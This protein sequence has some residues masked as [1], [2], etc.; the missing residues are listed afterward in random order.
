MHGER[1]NGTKPRGAVRNPA[2]VISSSPSP[3]LP[4]PP[5]AVARSWRSLHA[6]RYALRQEG[7]EDDEDD[8]ETKDDGR[9]QR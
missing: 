4:P 1:R 2:P 5:L 3:L 7:Q 6:S 8:V 9:W